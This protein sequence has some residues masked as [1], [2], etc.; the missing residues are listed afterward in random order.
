MEK[1]I[2][3]LPF[4][5][6]AGSKDPDKE[7]DSLVKERTKSKKPPMF[8]V[9]LHNDDYT[10]QEW[11]VLILKKYFHKNHAEAVR[12]MLYVHHN[13]RAVVGVFP[14]DIAATKVDQVT[15]ASK[16]AGYPLLCTYEIN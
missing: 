14:R 9:L 3:Y 13:G 6:A 2:Q 15:R 7:G 10:T 5:F 16:E 11:V 4:I 1:Q 8:K 12:L